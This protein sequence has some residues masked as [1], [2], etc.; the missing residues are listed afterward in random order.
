[1]LINFEIWHISG[2]IFNIKNL[3]NKLKGHSPCS[4]HFKGP[5]FQVQIHGT[6]LE[7]FTII[8]RVLDSR[9]KR[10]FWPTSPVNRGFTVKR[11]TVF[12]SVRTW[13]F[14]SSNLDS[15]TGSQLK[16][17]LYLRNPYWWDFYLRELNFWNLT[18][19]DSYSWY[20]HDFYDRKLL[21]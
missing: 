18:L 14:S 8:K 1:M 11:I 19:R 21:L 4:L 9:G 20:N 7:K 10:L 13:S 6:V 5:K 17:H 2:A 15:L 12:H 16:E 3:I